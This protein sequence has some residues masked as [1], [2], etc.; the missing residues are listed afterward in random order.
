MTTAM[1]KLKQSLRE[2]SNRSINGRNETPVQD[3]NGQTSR[4]LFDLI[5]GMQKILKE[6]PAAELDP[7]FSI[8]DGTAAELDPGFTPK[9]IGA[10]RKSPESYDPGFTPR[11][12]TDSGWS[13]AYKPGSSIEDIN[14]IFYDYSRNAGLDKSKAAFLSS[15]SNDPVGDFFS[16]IGKGAENVWDNIAKFFE[17]LAPHTESN[18]SQ[19][20]GKNDDKK[21]DAGNYSVSTK[22]L[23]RMNEALKTYGYVKDNPVI[24]AFSDIADYGITFA[25]IDGLHKDVDARINNFAQAAWDMGAE[26]YNKKNDRPGCRYVGQTMMIPMTKNQADKV[27]AGNGTQIIK[28]FITD[29]TNSYVDLFDNGVNDFVGIGNTAEL[30]GK[31]WSEL[32]SQQ[33]N[34][35]INSYLKV[36]GL[37]HLKGE[38]WDYTSEPVK[39][40]VADAVAELYFKPW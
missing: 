13:S 10:N 27:K 8:G 2:K 21:I 23:D 26:M 35:F 25:E 40:F 24:G 29:A 34:T 6:R 19:S 31:Y 36:F 1:E 16:D 28:N 38:Y 12:K 3:T 32:T 5:L 33:Q 9:N 22:V 18:D 37:S 11:D 30:K 7:G 20:S 14:R 17:G 4:N 39:D 15:E